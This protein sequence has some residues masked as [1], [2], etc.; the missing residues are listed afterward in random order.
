MSWP[1]AY[2][3]K[4]NPRS[5]HIKLKASV[6]HGLELIVP[7]R[8]NQ[9][10]IPA[11]LEKSKSWIMKQLAKIQ[12][13]LQASDAHALPTQITLT[14]INQTWSIS[15]LASN[16]KLQIIPRPHQ[17]LVLTG[18]IENK[19]FCKKILLHWLK[20]QAKIHL[21]SELRNLSE[22]MQL[23]FKGVTIRSQE[24][25]WGSCSKE[26]SINLNFKLL[27][28]PPHLV[29]YV[30][31][32]ELCHTVFLNHSTKFWRF[33]AAFDPQWKEHSR[34]LRRTEKWIPVW[35]LS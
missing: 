2:T 24:T 19:T 14:A 30:M 15:Y 9:Q 23:P 29:R 16:T 25:R 10:E 7:R 26:K 11:I 12:V 21:S 33:V 8:F 20:Q 32:H 34:E 28:L 35:V 4:E 27:L 13:Q 18:N 1:P 3:L 31:I 17:E 6:K 5:R 22:Q